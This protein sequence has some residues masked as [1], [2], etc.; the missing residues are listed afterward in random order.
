LVA[1]GFYPS[2]NN[3]RRVALGDLNRDGR[4]DAVAA[5]TGAL[6]AIEVHLT[7]PYGALGSG[8]P[9]SQAWY[10][11]SLA[12]GDLNRDGILDI[13]ASNSASPPT[14]VSSYL[15][16]GDGTFGTRNDFYINAGDDL[17]IGDMN[18][19]GIP[20]VV[21]AS[22]DS[23]QVLLGSGDGLFTAFSRARVGAC[24]DLELADINRDGMLDVVV[25]GGAVSI[26][27]A[28]DASGALA[29]PV[30]VPG[31][32]SNCH[33]LCV[34]DLNRDGFPDILATQSGD[35]YVFWGA[36]SSPYS[37]YTVTAL[38]YAALDMETGE[39]AGDGVPYVYVSHDPER[40]EVLSVGPT[41][42]LTAVSG[43]SEQVYTTP[44]DI[45]LGDIDRDGIVDVVTACAGSFFVT[46][47]PHGVGVVTAVGEVP[48]AAPRAMLAQNIPNPFNPSTEIRFRVAAADEA[49]LDVYDVH[50][51]LVRVLREGHFE[52]GEYRVRWDG[53]DQGGRHVGSGVFFYE[54]TT[55]SGAREARRMILL[56]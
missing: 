45:A 30:I 1:T 10:A 35:Y 4:I 14:R 43:G 34:T 11:S 20:D 29:A 17:E 7:N 8:I 12:L 15:G 5:R 18:H 26:L 22:Q 19:D 37:T 42:T 23:V 56:K 31:P 53:T 33:T 40:V 21:T 48:R 49:R 2:F 52:T 3:P 27:Y 44:E 6:P 50:G 13:V 25:A 36:A 32:V 46:V 38:P 28:A 16:I 55:R 51:R 47:T 54:L 9:L 41:G 39:A 24:Y